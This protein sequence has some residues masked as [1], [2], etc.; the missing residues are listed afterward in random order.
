MRTDDATTAD[1]LDPE[2][3][4]ERTFLVHR[5]DG[6][7]L[8]A[9]IASLDRHRAVEA[10]TRTTETWGLSQAEAARLFGVSRQAVG[11]WRRRGVPPERAGAVADLAAATDLLVRHLKRDR[12]PAVVRRPIPARDGVSLVDLLGQ[13]D[14]GA[15]LA[16]CRDM[17]RFDRVHA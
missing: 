17:F 13:G 4:A 12:I 5:H 9:F 14:T 1:A 16:A 8:D 15:V 7:W 2:E 11:K 3:A 6:E 10:F